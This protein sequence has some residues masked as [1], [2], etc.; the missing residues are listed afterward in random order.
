[1]HVNLETQK[2]LLS[3]KILSISHKSKVILDIFKPFW[4]F[5]STNS[6]KLLLNLSTLK[7]TPHRHHQ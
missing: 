4:L 1:M 7:L 5:F 3:K 6:F 2:K